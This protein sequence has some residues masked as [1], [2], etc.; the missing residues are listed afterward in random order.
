M[1]RSAIL[2]L[3]SCLAAAAAVLAAPATAH[4][5]TYIGAIVDFGTP[6]GRY[7]P[8][9]TPT[10]AGGG[11]L[12]YR[13]GLGPVFLQPEVMGHYTRFAGDGTSGRATRI[14]GGGRFGLSG[15]FQPAIYGH[16]GLG[17]LGADAFAPAFDV[18]LHLGFK[19][20]PYFRFGAQVGYN[21]I[22]AKTNALTYQWVSYGLNAGVEF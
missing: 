16:A 13:I 18:G 10:I 1:R 11:N 7:T 2:G 17:I 8:G 4:A 6:V 15:L 21:V 3:A 14:L 12:G 22:S 9:A 5:G 19:L 20:V